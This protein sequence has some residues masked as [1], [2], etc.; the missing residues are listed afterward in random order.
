MPARTTLSLQYWLSA[1]LT[2]FNALFSFIIFF[3]RKQ[4]I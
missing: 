2:Y 1:E 3:L 4:K